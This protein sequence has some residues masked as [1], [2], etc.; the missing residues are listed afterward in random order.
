MTGFAALDFADGSFDSFAHVFANYNSER[1]EP[2]TLKISLEAGSFT[3][4]LYALDKMKQKSQ[5]KGEN[6][7]PVKKFKMMMEAAE[8]AKRIYRFAAALSNE[9]FNIKEMRVINK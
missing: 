5:G 3:L 4:T 9:K 2:V 6:E 7:L 8:F 1:F